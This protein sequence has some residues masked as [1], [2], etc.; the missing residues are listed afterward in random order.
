HCALTSVLSSCDIDTHC[1]TTHTLSPT[2]R[3][4]DLER[5]SRLGVEAAVQTASV[6]QGDRV[7]VLVLHYRRGPPDLLERD[8]ALGR[9]AQVRR[10]E[11]HTSELQ[12]P[13]H[14]VCRLLLANKK[15]SKTKTE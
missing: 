8:A 9:A 1:T 15:Y 3:S 10:S 14:I 4:S 6:W 12:S 5:D 13:D 7:G 2:R 11:E